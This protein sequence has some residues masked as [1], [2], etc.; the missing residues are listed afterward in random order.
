MSKYK[1]RYATELGI[2][3]Y[4]STPEVQIELNRL[5]WAAAIANWTPSV[6]LLPVSGPG[7]ALYTVFDWTITLN[8][9]ITETAPDLLRYRNNKKLEA[10]GVSREL[11]D[12]FLGHNYYSPSNHTVITEYLASMKDAKGQARVIEQALQANSEIDA[13]TYQQIVEILAGYNRSV[14]PIIDLWVHKGI[15]VGYGKNGS[16]V[17]GVPVDLGRWTAFSE[18]LVEDFGKKQPG[19]EEI[20]KPELWIFG[21]LT[22]RAQREFVKLGISVTEHAD[23]KVG[24]MD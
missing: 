18:Y 13:F 16:L 9:V 6:L 7:K 22:Q 5:G 21:A 3:V 8:R 20:K 14:S 17:M 15:P 4:T 23:T 19:S 10:M 11:R 12:R 24:M 2:D 1:R